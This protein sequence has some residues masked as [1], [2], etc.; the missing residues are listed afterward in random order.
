MLA[1]VDASLRALL[2]AEAVGESGVD[3]VFDAPDAAWAAKLGSPL[4]DAHL[5]EIREDLERRPADWEDVREEQGRIVARRPPLRRFRL[6]Y[7]VTAWAP[8]VEQE[9]A[10]LSRVLLCLSAHEAIPAEHLT[11]A[12]ASEGVPVYLSV[13]P[14]S[15]ADPPPWAIWAALGVSARTCL[16]VVVLAPL[17]RPTSVATAPPV[18]SRRASIWASPMAQPE[19]LPTQARDARLQRLREAASPPGA[20]PAAEAL[21]R[22]ALR[23]RSA[24][25]RQGS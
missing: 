6:R 15:A 8:G 24:A 2:R 18:K 14:P 10:L 16:D 25:R 11:G 4:I 7:L 17:P 1:E 13:A 22:G 9:H 3:M 19:I 5:V 12:L 21:Q 23:S 20:G